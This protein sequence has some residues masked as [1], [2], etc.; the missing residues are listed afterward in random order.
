M[1][2]LALCLVLFITHF[3]LSTY[4]KLSNLI[5]MVIFQSYFI[6]INRHFLT[7]CFFILP[8]LQDGHFCWFFFYSIQ[9]FIIIF[10]LRSVT[11]C[12][13]LDKTMNDHQYQDKEM[14]ERHYDIYVESKHQGHLSPI[15][16]SIFYQRC[17]QHRTGGISLIPFDLIN[18]YMRED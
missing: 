16:S 3:S 1:V 4:I 6:E 17:T 11:K 8:F 15:I 5:C 12:L 10:A 2:G 9:Y 18:L 13:M 14:V 7:S